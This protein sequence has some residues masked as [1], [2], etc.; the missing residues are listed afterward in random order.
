M[1]KKAILISALLSG[2]VLAQDNSA[3]GA[4]V[5]DNTP[6]VA[7]VQGVTT[8]GFDDI[9]NL[10]GWITD[11]RSNPVGTTDWFQGNTGVFNAQAGPADSYIGANFNNTAGSDI[12][13]WLIMPDLGFLQS[14]NFW[15][16][17]T[18]ANT[19]PDRMFVVHSP[20]GGTTTGDCFTDFGDFT[21][22]L[23]E[24]NPNLDTGGYPDDW[25]QFTANV[26][27]SGRVAFVYFVANGGPV[28]ANSNFIGIDS[29][30]WVAG[31]PEA[32]LQLTVVSDAVGV[33]AIGDTVTFTE[34]VTNNGPADATNTAVASA[35]PNGLL[36]V[37][38]TCGATL[39]GS[40]LNW[41]VG[42]LT[43]GS[44]QNCD[45]VTTVDGFGQLVL[46]ATASADETDVV[47]G[48]NGATA[49][50]NGPVRIIPT[51]SQY[52]M[53]L[54]LVGLFFFARRKIA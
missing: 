29:V 37:S 50:V 26:N 15:T 6:P 11:N 21:N 35:I 4:F 22:S 53:L 31:V 51:L 2:S 41:A 44:S 7:D 48:N 36:Y 52:G 39:A 46:A 40:T 42:T 24:I 28:G 54:L 38:N 47:A 23:V 43:N 25:T 45:I 20:T 10:P 16:R 18:L 33:L 5:R 19:F 32:D 49:A 17:T 30:D 34:T 1:I 3:R 13:N 8:E 27:G 12:C 14:V 9:T